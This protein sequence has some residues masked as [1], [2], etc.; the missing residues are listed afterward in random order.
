MLLDAHRL[1]QAM[2]DVISSSGWLAPALGC[3]EL[4]QM[5]T[6]A[7]WDKDPPLMQLP[8]ITREIATKCREKEIEGVIDL[9]EMEV[10]TLYAQSVWLLHVVLTETAE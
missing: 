5:V 7:L 8:F 1:L 3:M 9:I 4:S 10:L 6:Q 2:V